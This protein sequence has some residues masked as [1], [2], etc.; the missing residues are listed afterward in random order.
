MGLRLHLMAGSS[1]VNRSRELRPG[2]IRAL[3]RDVAGAGLRYKIVFCCIKGKDS[4]RFQF[5]VSSC[6]F[7][8]LNK[9]KSFA[10][11]ELN[12]FLHKLKVILPT[13]RVI[14]KTNGMPACLPSFTHSFN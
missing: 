14:V 10:V 3:A 11:S 8:S 12:V 1:Q 4:D 7:T 13:A 5:G 2:Y 6:N 9:G